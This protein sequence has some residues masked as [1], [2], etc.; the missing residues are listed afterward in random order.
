MFGFSQDCLPMSR[1]DELNKFFNHAGSVRIFTSFFF[2]KYIYEVT[3]AIILSQMHFYLAFGN[4]ELKIW[5]IM[6]CL[7]LQNL[8]IDQ[9]LFYTNETGT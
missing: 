4:L 5:C 1:W 2:H 9:I 8:D 6:F 7:I 3:V